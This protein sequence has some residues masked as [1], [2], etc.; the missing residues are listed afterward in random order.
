MFLKYDKLIFH[1]TLAEDPSQTHIY[2][3]QT[4]GV[5]AVPPVGLLPAL[6]DVPAA[7]GGREDQEGEA[8]TQGSPQ[9][10]GD[11]EH[12]GEGARLGGR[13]LSDDHVCQH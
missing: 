5:Y 11:M 2:F 3:P 6:Q 4:V 8:A 1:Q 7:H 12:R 13:N 9:Q 10:V